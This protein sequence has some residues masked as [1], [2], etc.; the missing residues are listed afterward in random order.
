MTTPSGTIFS[1][2]YPDGYPT[3]MRCTWKLQPPKDKFIRVSFD[4]LRMQNCRYASLEVRDIQTNKLIARLCQDAHLRPFIFFSSAGSGLVVQF[5]SSKAYT[6]GGF[7][8]SYETTSQCK[9]MSSHN[10]RT[11]CIHQKGFQIKFACCMP[12]I[13][14]TFSGGA[15]FYWHFF[16]MYKTKCIKKHY[17]LC[18]ASVYLLWWLISKW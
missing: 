17:F 14:V 16:L 18:S 12:T 3:N 11:N 9:Y 2:R 8:A 5:N 6:W 10:T 1:P 15:S 7:T 13:L 4:A